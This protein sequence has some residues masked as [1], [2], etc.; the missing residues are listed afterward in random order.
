MATTFL[1][2]KEACKQNPAHA[3]LIRAVV[4]QFGGMDN[5]T[6]QMMEDILSHGIDGGF[7]G[8]IYYSDTCKFAVKHQ[9]QINALLLEQYRSLGYKNPFEMVQ[10]FGVFNQT[11]AG[12][13]CNMMDNEEMQD[14]NLFLAGN[15]GRCKGH[16]VTNV[17]AWYAAEEVCRMFLP[18][19]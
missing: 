1:S 6:P 5:D 2:M 8:F 18:E 16:T 4:K 11:I 9:K 7:Y 10:E 12:L 17:L 3:K 13:R 14:V 19:Y 15:A